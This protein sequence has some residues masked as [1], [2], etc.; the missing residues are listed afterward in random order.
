MSYLKVPKYMRNIVIA[1]V[2][3]STLALSLYGIRITFADDSS[4]QNF[5]NETI[6]MPANP[7]TQIRKY[8]KANKSTNPKKYDMK[9]SWHGHRK[10]N[11]SPEDLKLKIQSALEAG[12]INQQDAESKLQHLEKMTE[13]GHMKK[14]R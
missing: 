14:V 5:H 10:L 11:V 4:K 1:S 9:K 3:I 7:E 12:K 6:E 2:L 8:L 13:K